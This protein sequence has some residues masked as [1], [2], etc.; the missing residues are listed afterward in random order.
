VLRT[1]SKAHGLAGLRIGYAMAR[2]EHARALDHVREAFNASSLAQ[3]AALGALDDEAHVERTRAVVETER[4][5]LS[6]R[7]DELDLEH[8]PSVTNF[9]F[10]NIGTRAAE[11]N[12]AL[13]SRGVVIRPMSAPGIE[14]WARISVGDRVGN[15]RLVA[16]LAD[17]LA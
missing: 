9:L 12:E 8:V 4:A 14:S 1:F 7:F 13:L 11:V 6:A 17:A 15:E 16:A 3:A 5:W 2:S 10:T